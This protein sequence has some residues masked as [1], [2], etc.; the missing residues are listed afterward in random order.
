MSLVDER[1]GL[2]AGRSASAA[3]PSSGPQCVDLYLDL[4]KKS[5]T[6]TV[7]EPEPDIDDDDRL[8]FVKDFMSHYM[9][10]QAVC[11]CPRVRLD[12][13]E[14]CIADVLEREIPGDLIETGVWRGGTTIFMRAV[15]KAHGVADRRVWVCDSF[16]GLPEPDPERFPVESESYRAPVV[17][18]GYKRFAA[19]LEEVQRNFAAYGMLDG[20]VEFVK[21]WFRDTLPTLPVGKL[22]IMRL[23]G[24]YYESTMDGLLNL[25]DKLSIGGYAIIDDYGEDSWT[26]CRKAVDEF[27]K[28][29]DIREPMVRVDS[30]C[31]QW[32][33]ER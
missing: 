16:E 27:R 30:K 25:Y 26:Y 6:N 32:R 21:G 8:N 31:Y 12:S 14:S 3:T 10:S 17:A 2:A 20:Q 19:S 29:N 1:A 28:Q 24:D 9:E 13:L 11:M 7:F 33:R 22:A 18:K 15:L 4:L 5:L 23:D